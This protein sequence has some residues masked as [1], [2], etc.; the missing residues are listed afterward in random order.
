MLGP[1][2]LGRGRGALPTCQAALGSWELPWETMENPV[3]LTTV[4]FLVVAFLW[5]SSSLGPTL[6]PLLFRPLEP[7]VWP[8]WI[9]SPQMVTLHFYTR[10]A[11]L[12]LS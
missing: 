9:V 5:G 2:G 4:A 3:V 10:D 11:S 8:T 1:C 7:V 6:T 12:T